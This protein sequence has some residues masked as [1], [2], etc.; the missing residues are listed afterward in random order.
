MTDNDNDQKIESR[1]ERTKRLLKEALRE[2]PTDRQLIELQRRRLNEEAV[3]L[4]N[5]AWAIRELLSS[6]S[7]EYLPLPE[8]VERVRDLARVMQQHSADLPKLVRGD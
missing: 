7:G 1:S 2:A 4:G 6:D 8:R 5:L 3:V